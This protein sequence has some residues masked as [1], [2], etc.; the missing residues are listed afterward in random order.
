MVVLPAPLGPA[1]ATSWLGP[2]WRL[3]PASASTG[4]PG[5]LDEQ[6]VDDADRRGH[7]DQPGDGGHLGPIGAEQRHH[8][9]GATLPAR[10]S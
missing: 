1:S 4:A 8:P 6:R 9:A 10:K 2:A 5:Y 3:T 7:H